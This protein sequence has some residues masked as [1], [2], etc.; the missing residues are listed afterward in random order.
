[1]A[2]LTL[3]V[4]PLRQR[5]LDAMEVRGKAVRTQEAYVQ[6]VAHLG[7]Y[8]KC[9]PSQLTSQLVQEYL[10]HLL[11]NHLPWQSLERPLLHSILDFGDR[12]ARALLIELTASGTAHADPAD[13][14]RASHQGHASYGKCDIWKLRLRHCRR[15]RLRHPVTHFLGTPF[16]AAECQGSCRV[17][18]VVSIVQR[19]NGCAIASQHGL[20]NSI[21]V[22]DDRDHL[23]ASLSTNRN[24]LA[25]K[26]VR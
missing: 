20:A 14:D 25:D 10:L 17:S 21:K 22:H 5:M 4:S 18:L 12:G 2:N 19:V 7:K 24:G 26:L 3:K 23:M 16:V 9:S 8:F 1:M 15:R 13:R 11:R 6:A